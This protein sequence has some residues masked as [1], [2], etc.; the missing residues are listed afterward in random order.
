MCLGK[1]PR[2]PRE[3]GVR[4]EAMGCQ[5]PF[6]EA[7]GAR[8]TP[9]DSWVA[10]SK[11]DGSRITWDVGPAS[12]SSKPAVWGMIPVPMMWDANRV[13][14]LPGGGWGVHCRRTGSRSRAEERSSRRVT[15]PRSQGGAYAMWGRQRL[16][17]RVDTLSL[18]LSWREHIPDL[19]D[20]IGDILDVAL[21][22]V[23]AIR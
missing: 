23:V 11:R 13:K 19:A 20:E 2:R 16:S 6:V 1:G 18:S 7:D 8:M 4:D 15:R 14:V 21:A 12:C 17:P 3:G 10:L 22:Y 9:P 5:A